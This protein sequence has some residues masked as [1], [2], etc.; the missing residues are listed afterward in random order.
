MEKLTV[1]NYYLLLIVLKNM[2]ENYLRSMKIFTV[3]EYNKR[4]I[5]WINR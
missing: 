5:K 3:N 1:N 2:M 4:L